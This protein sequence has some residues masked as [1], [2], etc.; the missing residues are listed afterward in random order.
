MKRMMAKHHI[1]LHLDRL[2]LKIQD[3]VIVQMIQLL[4]FQMVEQALLVVMMEVEV[5]VEVQVEQK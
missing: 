2:K 3:L 5:Q 1:S 4:L